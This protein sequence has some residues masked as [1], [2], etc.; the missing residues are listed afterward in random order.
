MH[1]F[2]LFVINFDYVGG[3][4]WICLHRWKY[5][6]S[7]VIEFLTILAKGG[8]SM[9]SWRGL[10]EMRWVWHSIDSSPDLNRQM[11]PNVIFIITGSSWKHKLNFKP[12]TF[13]NHNKPILICLLKHIM[14]TV[15]IP[16][17]RHTTTC[18]HR[19][20]FCYKSHS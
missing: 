17:I 5:Y 20:K 19:H 11:L 14:S 4:H 1:I 10:K 8:I 18:A 15:D 6:E 12:S 9:A 3:W 16:W 13:T 2:I 7:K